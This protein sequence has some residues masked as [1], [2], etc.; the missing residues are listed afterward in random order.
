MNGLTHLTEFLKLLTS[1]GHP[2]SLHHYRPDAIMVA[3]AVPGSRYEIYFFE[4]HV[5]ISTFNGDE[6]V[7]RDLAPVI[8][9]VKEE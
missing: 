9:I 4:D 2:F 5:E 8:A 7:S 6:S 1:C 3:F